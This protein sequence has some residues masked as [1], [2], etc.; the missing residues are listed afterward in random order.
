[1]SEIS[2]DAFRHDTR[3]VAPRPYQD[4]G[5]EVAGARSHD[6]TPE[7]A[8]PR[9]HDGSP[10]V[11]ARDSLEAFVARITALDASIDEVE[12]VRAFWSQPVDEGDH[13]REALLR[14]SD[15]ELRKLI[16]DGRAEF[17][18][19]THD[20]AEQA[21]LD[22]RRA[23]DAE[24]PEAEN[25]TAHGTVER[26]IEWVGGEPARAQAALDAE[27]S[28]PDHQPRRTLVAALE[29]VLATLADES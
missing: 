4:H 6:G 28:I 24:R 5:P 13:T 9:A 26:V 12:A 11:M 20:E 23:V 27:H 16:E 10:E 22:W 3:E 17:E 15:D 7:V 2:T 1:M 21:D 19:G 14:M 25:Q 8:G 29:G 18:V